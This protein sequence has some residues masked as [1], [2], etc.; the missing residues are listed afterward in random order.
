MITI[1]KIATDKCFAEVPLEKF[2]HTATSHGLTV[3]TDLKFGCRRVVSGWKFYAAKKGTV[4]FGIWRLDEDAGEDKYSLVGK[5][6][7]E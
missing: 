7:V 2:P 1:I 5:T 6:K 3:F 4:Y